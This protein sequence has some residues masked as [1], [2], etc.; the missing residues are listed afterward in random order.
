[1]FTKGGVDKED[2]GRVGVCVCMYI[3][4]C[5]YLLEY[6]SAKRKKGV[7]PFAAT[8]MGIMLSEVSQRKSNTAWYHLPVVSKKRSNS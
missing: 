1:M 8:W 3:C 6:Y 2:E 5:I 7:L 4:T